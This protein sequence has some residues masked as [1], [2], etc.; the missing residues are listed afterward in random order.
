MAYIK[1]FITL[2]LAKDY[3]KITIKDIATE[4]DVDRK[5]V[6]NYYSG[7]FEIREELEND[8]TK[9][10]DEIM[11][12]PTSDDLYTWTLKFFRSFNT[13]VE[14]N[15]DLFGYL[16]RYN[17]QTRMLQ[18]FIYFIRDKLTAIMLE[19]DMSR[20][21][22]EKLQMIASFASAG[23]IIVYQ[24]WFVGGKTISLEELSEDLTKLVMDGVN[25]FK[26]P[27]GE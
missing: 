17:S 2:L 22:Q 27:L 14:Q 5:T 4:A 26:K 15:A 1:A 11:S 25:S 13:V 16:F 24:N 9:S 6:Y 10:L 7:I 23:S 21:G 3:N 8:I 19:S 12:E 18:K 20:Y